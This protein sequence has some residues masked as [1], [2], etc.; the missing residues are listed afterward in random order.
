VF[1]GVYTA[2]YLSFGVPA[3]IAGQLATHLGV[4]PTVEGYAVVVVAAA[5]VALVVQAL[6]A[7]GDRV[8]AMRAPVPVLEREPACDAA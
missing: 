8:A 1:A 3:I 2:A 6:L 7:R 5:A 4:L